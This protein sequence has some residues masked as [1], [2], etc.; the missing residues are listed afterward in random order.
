MNST[1][2]AEKNKNGNIV[3]TL[4]ALQ[5]SE[6]EQCLESATVWAFVISKKNAVELS[7]QLLKAV[8][9]PQGDKTE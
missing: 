4:K 2:K 9:A 8:R 1:A 7:Q 5:S 6:S 3:I